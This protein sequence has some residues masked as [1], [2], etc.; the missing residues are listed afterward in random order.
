LVLVHPRDIVSDMPLPA[1]REGLLSLA[2]QTEIELMDLTDTGDVKVMKARADALGRLGEIRARL[3]ESRE[4]EER[5]DEAAEAYL[6]L[7]SSEGRDLAT[8]TQIRQASL[9]LVD[10][11]DREAVGIIERMIEFN[12]GFPALESIPGMVPVGLVLWLAGLDR[13]K[14]ARRLY[15]ASGVALQT[16][17]P[18]DPS[19]AQTLGQ[20]LAW[21]AKSAEELGLK[22]EAVASY[23]RAIPVL[24]ASDRPE[25]NA[26]W[27]DN[28]VTSLA[29]LLVQLDRDEE[30][31]DA[32]RHA[33]DHYE[34]K[35][36]LRARPFVAVARLFA[37]R[38]GRSGK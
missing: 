10:N 37:L 34:S 18:A 3:G 29:T 4:A 38:L 2:T 7:G 13:I 12:D 27:L 16:L 1:D 35:K 26:Y 32:F 5:L 17:D 19:H 15:D 8:A 21:R 23:R 6:K 25:A 28:A 31:A 14:D 24:E 22:S 30:A 20:T 36:K 9:A 33:A 11:R